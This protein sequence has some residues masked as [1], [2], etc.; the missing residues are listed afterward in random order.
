[1]KVELASSIDTRSKSQWPQPI[2]LLMNLGK[3]KMAY[4]LGPIDP[5]R[6]LVAIIAVSRMSQWLEDLLLSQPLHNCLSKKKK[7]SQGV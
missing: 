6:N 7:K 2:S 4:V 5:M 1:M 3:Q